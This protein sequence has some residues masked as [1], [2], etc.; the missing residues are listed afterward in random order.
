MK[1]MAVRVL[2]VVMAISIMAGCGANASNS[3]AETDSDETVR[4]EAVQSEATDKEKEFKGGTDAP[5]KTSGGGNGMGLQGGTASQTENSDEIQAV[6]DENSDKF[7]QFTYTDETSG[8]ALGYSLYIPDN[9]DENTEYPLVMYIPDSTC[10][11]KTAEEIVEQYY[12]A[13]VW[14]TDEDQEKHGCFVFVPAF[15]E[16]VVD[17]NFTVS[18]QVDVVVR[19]L[20]QLI[21]DYSIDTDRLYTTGQSMGC[22]VSLYLNSLYPDFFA[23]SLYVSGQWDISTLGNLENQKFFYIVAGGDEKASAGQDSVMEMFDDD[24]VPYS[25]AEWNA[26]ND[27]DTQN[28]D[29][30]EL[31]SQNL[32]ANMIRFETGSVLTDAS[33]K[34]HMESF[35]Y[36]YDISVVRDWVFE[37][38][39]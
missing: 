8:I 12:G 1:K 24:Q 28:S 19:L 14:V 32:N 22:M 23:A 21:E 39:R 26:Q 5:G 16:V 34:E 18:E 29:A 33:G 10:V 35:N 38:S 7:E 3:S 15:T 37:Q 27:S 4:S 11:G 9:Y 31:I 30:G 17:D 36:A 6:I 25:Y 13:N 20:N 2:G